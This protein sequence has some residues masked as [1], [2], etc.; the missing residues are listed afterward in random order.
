MPA[1]LS[2]VFSITIRPPIDELPEAA[3]V[4]RCLAQISKDYVFS[5]EKNNH[6]Q[7]G[8]TTGKPTRSDKVR[9]LI[10]KT[11]G[12]FSTTALVVKS[13]DDWAYLVGYCLKEEECLGTSLGTPDVDKYCKHYLTRCALLANLRGK[14]YLSMDDVADSV[15]EYHKVL[16]CAS[17]QTI[18]EALRSIKDMLRFSVYQR[19]N[20][21]KLLAYVSL[22]ILPPL[23]GSVLGGGTLHQEGSQNETYRPDNIAMEDI[24]IEEFL[25]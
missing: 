11:L 20:Q 8:I 1:K 12:K 19:I 7:C 4:D 25:C 5:K 14:K 6:Y 17:Q 16:S 18:N 15:V 22:Q 24:S 21:E 13:H 23:G 9:D 3:D 2:T 10:N